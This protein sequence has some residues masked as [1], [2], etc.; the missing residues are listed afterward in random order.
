M[1]LPELLRA[2]SALQRS[3]MLAL[4]LSCSGLDVPGFTWGFD[5]VEIAGRLYEPAP[6]DAGELALI[7]PYAPPGASI[8]EPD[9]LVCC[10]LSDRRIATR[11]GVA[12]ALGE[13]WLSLAAASRKPVILYDDPIRWLFHKMRG[14]V[15]VDWP[16]V[17]FL[18][19]LVSGVICDSRSLSQ[20]ITAATRRM[21]D[22]PRIFRLPNKRS[23]TN[24]TRR[25]A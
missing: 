23:F 3:R 12:Q 13:D 4:H 21:E 24:A 8:F 16:A 1:L 5:R 15:I 25:A 10:R 7:V 22:P 18:L 9:D 11:L 17:P 14:A 6:D 20:R 2:Q 19:D